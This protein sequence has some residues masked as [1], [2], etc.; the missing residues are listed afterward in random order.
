MTTI[1]RDTK[2]GGVLTDPTSFT[3]EDSTAAFGVKRN[4]TD[5]VLV[6]AG[7]AMTQI[8]TGRYSYTW[9]DP[10]YDLTYTVAMKLVAD[11]HTSINEETISGPSD[12]SGSLATLARAQQNP[13]LANV[14]ETFLSNL[15]KAAGEH[16][17]KTCGRV[18]SETD[19]TDEAYDGFWERSLILDHFP[20]IAL[21]SVTITDCA[22][23]EI[24][25]DGA[26]F[27]I[28][29]DI[30]EIRFKPAA[31]LTGTYAHFPRGYQNITVT[32]TSGFASVPSD[33]QEGCVQMA[34]FLHSSNQTDPSYTSERLGAYQWARE[35][36][37]GGMPSSIRALISHY[38]D[39]KI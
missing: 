6:A 15:L 33:V 36:L 17:E 20:I 21:D 1:F 10:A 5:E 34:M 3:L 4:D 7:T 31:Q 39:K 13:I 38:V 12:L 35:K 25:I 24:D 27:D 30:G 11:G 8:A 14:D 16:I 9:E 19:R 29:N 32:Y 18:F 28:K 23:T 22:G 2:K 37:N 26:Q